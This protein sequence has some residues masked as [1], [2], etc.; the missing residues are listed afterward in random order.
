M[1]ALCRAAA[2]YTTCCFIDIEL[3]A[4]ILSVNKPLLT[5]GD[6]HFLE[7]PWADTPTRVSAV[8]KAILNP[9]RH[10]FR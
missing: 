4:S 5:R 9:S 2:D 8:S 6:I 7:K 1:L 3:R 10:S